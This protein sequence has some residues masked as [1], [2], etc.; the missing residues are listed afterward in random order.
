MAVLAIAAVGAVAGGAVGASF[1]AVALG[2]S[3]GWAVG[4]FVGQLAF[5]PD[6]PTTQGPRLTDLSVQS[7]A[8]GVGI[9][10]VFGRPRIAGNV[11]WARPIQETRHE[12][13]VGGKGMGGGG[14]Q[15]S[16]TYS[17]SFAIG[18]CEGPII[19][20]RK[21]WADSK[22][23]YDVSA[24]ADAGTLQVS[25]E[26][27]KA[28]RVYTGSESQ[29]ADPSIQSFE[30]AA[31]TPA[32]RGLAYLMFEDLQL[33]DFANHMPNITCEVLSAGSTQG[34]RLLTDNPTEVDYTALS[35]V[36]VAYFDLNKVDNGVFQFMVPDVAWG[37][38]HEKLANT[39]YTAGGA[40]FR[41]TNSLAGAFLSREKVTYPLFNGPSNL[42]TSGYVELVGY[43]GGLPVYF[44]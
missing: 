10:I 11:I 23:I 41:E 36:G 21:I 42:F 39:M 8:E 34:L 7:S 20:V 28:T 19:G 1:G 2:A 5:G 37:A 13:K 3:I 14:T 22:L 38:G 35:G 29:T 16:Y 4:S 30:G 25:Q 26:L 17:V 33:A 24:S 18:L 6:P 27:A 44:S 31:N 40:G 12:E 9:P 32:Y 15:V 43:L